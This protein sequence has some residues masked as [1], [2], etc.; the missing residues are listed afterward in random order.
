MFT[1]GEG[2]YPAICIVTVRSDGNDTP[3]ELIDNAVRADC[4]RWRLRS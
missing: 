1:T 2:R 3:Q 4:T